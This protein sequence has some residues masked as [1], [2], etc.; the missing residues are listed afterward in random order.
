M[1]TSMNYDDDDDEADEEFEGYDDDNPNGN[2][3]YG[4]NFNNNNN[5]NNIHRDDNSSSSINLSS[6][7]QQ[8]QQNITSNRNNNMPFRLGTAPKEWDLGLVPNNNTRTTTIRTNHVMSNLKSNSSLQDQ[9]RRLVTND[10]TLSIRKEE[11]KAL[12]L[13]HQQ[14]QQKSVEQQQTQNSTRDEDAYNLLELHKQQRPHHEYLTN[15]F[16][17]ANNSVGSVMDV[18]ATSRLSPVTAMAGIS[19]TVN[20]NSRSMILPTIQPTIMESLSDNNTTMAPSVSQYMTN[21]LSNED[22]SLGSIPNNVSKLLP[23]IGT[24]MSRTL[25]PATSADS[26][27]SSTMPPPNSDLFDNHSH[28]NSMSGIIGSSLSRAGIPPGFGQTIQTSS[29]SFPTFGIG[30]IW[31]GYTEQNKQ[32]STNPFVIDG[33]TLI[34]LQPADSRIRHD[35]EISLSSSVSGLKSTASQITSFSNNNNNNKLDNNSISEHTSSSHPR[36]KKK[37]SQ[38]STNTNTPEQ[39][40]Q[41]SFHAPKAALH[42]VY[43]K[44]PRRKVVSGDHF[45]SFHDGGPAHILRWTCIF[46]CPISGELF[47]AVPYPSGGSTVIDQFPS[48]QNHYQPIWGRYWF[49]KKLQAEHGAA[50]AAHDCMV[51]RDRIARLAGNIQQQNQQ[52]QEQPISS[53]LLSIIAAAENENEN[54]IDDTIYIST[55]KPYI[56]NVGIF[57]M[58]ES[59]IPPAIRAAV[60]MQQKEIWRVTGIQRET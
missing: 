27:T 11:R 45:H 31:G 10:N 2:V 39:Q 53:E 50:A 55:E 42:I 24:P 60:L 59:I 18:D 22:M 29:S 28:Q 16:N 9:G 13:N 32:L 17:S 34:P 25:L 20:N 37:N 21:N 33:K 47:V 54:N 4:Q 5:G 41:I 38:S 15:T 46:V 57:D 40:R 44:A 51:Y 12:F 56:A 43:G 3:H 14:Q 35:D 7:Q 36:K 49:P 26:S 48:E 8:R 52:Q 19:S 23:P 58:P 6:T 30:G 1:S